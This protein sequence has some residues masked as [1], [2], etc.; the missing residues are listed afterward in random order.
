MVISMLLNSIL[1]YSRL[2]AIVEINTIVNYY[3]LLST[4]INY[5]PQ[6]LTINHYYPRLST[7]ILLE[8][9]AANCQNSHTF[10]SHAHKTKGS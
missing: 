2:W 8:E 4:I 1:N 3:Q 10:G 6:L 9:Q 5:Y 7:I